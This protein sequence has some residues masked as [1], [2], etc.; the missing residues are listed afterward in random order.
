MTL[1]VAA[2]VL[3][4]SL[5][6]L[7]PFMPYLSEEL[8]QRLPV[9]EKEESVTIASFPDT[10]RVTIHPLI[11]RGQTVSLSNIDTLSYFK[12]CSSITFDVAS[13]LHSSRFLFTLPVHHSSRLYNGYDMLFIA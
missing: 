8:Y 7:S 10:S 11:V 1:S 5:I 6:C 2:E 13:K 12:D 4:T 9:Q 3:R